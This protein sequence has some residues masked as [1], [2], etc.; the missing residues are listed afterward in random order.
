MREME[1][2]ER[3]R[4]LC[5]ER[6]GA[7][8]RETKMSGLFRE[9]LL[10]KEQPRPWAGKFS[11]GGRICQVGTEGCWEARSALLCKICTSVPC[12]RVQKPHT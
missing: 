10:Q 6:R 8:Q 11:I 3:E 2:R 5:A 1:R 12:P 7:G 4:G 9:E